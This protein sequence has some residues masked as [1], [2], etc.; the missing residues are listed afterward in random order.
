M[1]TEVPIIGY[2]IQLDRYTFIGKRGRVF[3]KKV[4]NAETIFASE[5]SAQSYAHKH[6]DRV[7][8]QALII[9]IYKKEEGSVRLLRH[10][11]DVKPQEEFLFVERKRPVRYRKDAFRNYQQEGRKDRMK[12]PK[13]RPV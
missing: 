2:V 1:F 8:S 9:P 13:L 3:F 10:E 4:Q 7:L 5:V 12:I 11:E 6:K